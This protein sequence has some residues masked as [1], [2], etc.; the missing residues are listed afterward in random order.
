LFSDFQEITDPDYGNCYTYNYD[1]KHITGRGGTQYGEFFL[2]WSLEVESVGCKCCI[3]YVYV[4]ILP[5]MLPFFMF[6]W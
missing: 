4:E 5:R 6:M 2:G 1:G 3:F